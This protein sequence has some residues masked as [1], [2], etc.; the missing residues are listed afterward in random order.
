MATAAPGVQVITLNPKPGEFEKA[1]SNLSIRSTVKVVRNTSKEFW[2]T[3]GQTFEMIFV[4]GDHSRAMVLHDSQFFNRLQPGGAILFHDYS[5]DDSLRPSGGSYLAL[6]EL[7]AKHRKA[8]ITVVGDGK[9][10]MLGWIRREGEI[11]Q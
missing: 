2:A 6:N 10:G 8:D 4:D 11:W 3:D 1:S 7:Q 9:I 5:P